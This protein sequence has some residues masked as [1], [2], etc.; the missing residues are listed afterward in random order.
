MD[1]SPDDIKQQIDHTRARLDR[2]LNRLDAQ[3]DES[4]ERLVAASQWWL[5]VSAVAA[6]VGG[7]ILFWPRERTRRVRIVAVGA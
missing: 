3:L 6:G 7:A 5:G 2:D 1:Q 4:K